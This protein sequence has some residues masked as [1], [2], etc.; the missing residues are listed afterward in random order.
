V[1]LGEQR[2]AN[3][4]RSKPEQSTARQPYYDSGSRRPCWPRN[5]DG[6][7]RI[8][9]RYRTSHDQRLAFRDAS[10]APGAAAQPRGAGRGGT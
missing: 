7:R 5:R 4:V 10:V 3:L 2:Q 9:S 1:L 6:A 8:K